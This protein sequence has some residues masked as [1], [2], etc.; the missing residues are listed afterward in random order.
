MTEVKN[1]FPKILF[2]DAVL[3]YNSSTGITLTNLF[4]SWP[5][6]RLF[7]VGSYQDIKFSKLHNFNNIYVEEED[8]FAHLFPIGIIKKL[9]SRYL[10]LFVSRPKDFIGQKKNNQSNFRKSTHEKLTI[11][12]KI[13]IQLGFNYFFLRKKISPRFHEWVLRS[14]PD[15]VYA[16]LSSRHSILF[17]DLFH[18]EYEI[19]MII[20]IMDD[21]P[22]TIGTD[23]M[24]G[25]IW[26]TI[27]NKEF[28]KLILI[29]HRRVAISELMANE[30]QSRYNC[31]WEFFHNPIDLTKW[32][33]DKLPLRTNIRS[34]T[35]RFG[36]FGR[37]GRANETTLYT[38]IKCL[39]ELDLQYKIK[40]EF[41]IYSNNRLN[42]NL[43]KYSFITQCGF[44]E[45]SLIAREMLGFDFLFLPLSFEKEDSRFAR[46]SIPTKFSE[47]LISGIPCVAILP[48][49]FA[50]SKFISNYN[51]AFLINSIE[52][53]IV[54]GE[55]LKIIFDMA[56]IHK[57]SETS[58]LVAQNHFSQN[59]VHARFMH[60][61]N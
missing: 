24:F 16:V 51:C 11:F 2:L 40:V 31:K 10:R 18:K 29:S 8:D 1:K 25:K 49:N 27:I 54:I 47:Y 38:F 34:K 30:Y 14:K 20:H 21:W 26:N 45:H 50:L 52:T 42:P 41:V 5:K 37:I 58:R 43:S 15:F 57:V 36:Y 32:H 61:F 4:A 28:N 9:R 44:I 3:H 56:R 35:V 19:P 60:L 39:N 48:E 7:M 33:F 22:S 17:A 55:L 12:N 59:V 46:L 23:S 13:F 6:D 53:N